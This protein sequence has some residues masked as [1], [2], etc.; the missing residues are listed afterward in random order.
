MFSI[1]PFAKALYSSIRL[2]KIGFDESLHFL[3]YLFFK[4][5]ILSTSLSSLASRRSGSFPNS[6]FILVMLIG[7]LGLEAGPRPQPIWA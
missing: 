6:R 1:L 2:V 7:R 4:S 5:R 3:R